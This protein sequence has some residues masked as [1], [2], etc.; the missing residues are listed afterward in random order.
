MFDSSEGR[1]IVHTRTLD[2]ST[3]GAA[4]FSKHGDLTGSVVNL[5][6]AYPPR[7]DGEAPKVLKVG[8]RVVSTAR[9][10]GMSQY[11]HGLSFIRSPNDGLDALV[12]L[13]NT[14]AVV[15]PAL[16]STGSRLEQ[17]KRLAPAKE[18]KGK[19]LG[20]REAINA[21][22]SD[23]LEK[24]Y[25]Y[26][27][28]LKAHLNVVRPAFP[29]GYGIPG[30]PEFSGLVWEEAHTDLQMRQISPEVR[31]YER[32][33]LHYRLSGKK[34]IRVAREY[35]AADK[36]TQLL[37]DSNIKFDAQGTFNKRGSLER[38]TFEFPCDVAASLV[39]LGDF[40]TGE[41]LLDARNVSGFGS[42]KQILV[43]EAITDESLDE[44][45]RFIVGET[46]DLRLLLLRDA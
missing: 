15:T 45:K 27:K 10:P 31:L 39:L 25:R 2:L 34:Q 14:A 12:A 11:R 43:P 23:A 19:V 41:L 22:V 29:R 17:R 16:P 21:R 6:L 5:L 9:A 46:S 24:A 33:S 44:L 38:T 37:E 8:A 36:L 7:K 35:P 18:P 30:V 32:V 13:L 28:D 26:L 3:S 20:P 42:M 1:P 4:I 40:D